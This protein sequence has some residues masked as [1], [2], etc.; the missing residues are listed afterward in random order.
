MGANGTVYTDEDLQLAVDS[1]LFYYRAL[2][3]RENRLAGKERDDELRARFY[4][5]LPKT[6][7]EV[8]Q[9]RSAVAILTRS[10]A[11]L[12]FSGKGEKRKRLAGGLALAAHLRSL[13]NARQSLPWEDVVDATV[14]DFDGFMLSE[15]QGRAQLSILCDLGLA[16]NPNPGEYKVSERGLEVL[17]L[18]PHKIWRG[19]ERD[20]RVVKLTIRDRTVTIPQKIF[21]GGQWKWKPDQCVVRL[22]TFIKDQPDMCRAE[23]T[24]EGQDLIEAI[25][26]ANR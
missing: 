26:R 25:E 7:E 20:V 14:R 18:G 4:A 1:L 21:M 15:N 5:A 6:L 23:D 8:K 16:L 13:G 22:S 12:G 17:Q 2:R 10:L 24:E 19:T 9:R 3:N 11:R